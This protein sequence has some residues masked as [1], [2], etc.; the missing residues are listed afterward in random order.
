[1]TFRRRRRRKQLLDDLKEKRIL[2]IESGSTKWQSVENCLWKSL[3]TCRKTNHEMN[4][5]M[6]E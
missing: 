6:N 5:R 2:K 3:E 1:V 4:E